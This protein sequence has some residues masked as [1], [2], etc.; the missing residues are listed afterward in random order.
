MGATPAARNAGATPKSN[1]VA[2][3]TPV[4]N[5]RTRQSGERS[6]K[7][8]GFCVES[9]CTSNWLLQRATNSP[10]VAPTIDSTRLSVSSS[11]TRRHRDAPSARR[12]LHSCRRAVARA[13]C[14]FAMFAHAISSTRTTTTI[15][16]SSGRPYRAR[17]SESPVAAGASVNFALRYFGRSCDGQLPTGSVASRISGCTPRTASVAASI[18]SPGLSRTI[19]ESHHESREPSS[20]SLPW[21]AGSAPMG[22]A[23]STRWPTIGPKKSGGM[24]PTTVNGI[25]SSVIRRPTTSRV[26]PNRRCQSA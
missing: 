26:A 3:V 25:R 15:T 4:V 9:C 11:R 6:R 22:I 1:A 16:V 23:M 24:T 7:T 21:T 13:S 2:A 12:T 18:D 10:S 17:I 14:R 5:A 8:V 20:E 19:T